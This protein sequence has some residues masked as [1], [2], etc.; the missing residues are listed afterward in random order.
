MGQLFQQIRR[1]K[2]VQ[3]RVDS[4]GHM[5]VFFPGA[6][7]RQQT[8]PVRQ[9]R[10]VG[11]YR[12]SI[13]QS[14]KR[15]GG[16]E[17][18]PCCV[19]QTSG[20]S[21]PPEGSMGLGSVFDQRN[22]GFVRDPGKSL[23]VPYLPI[24]VDGQNC[25]GL[26]GDGRP[27]TFRVQGEMVRLDIYEHRAGAHA[28]DRQARGNEGMG[29]DDHLISGA[30]VHCQQDQP[31]RVQAAGAACHLLYAQIGGKGLFKPAAAV[32]LDILPGLQDLPGGLQ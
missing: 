17:A 25:P 1:L 12:A 14:A 10:I 4:P 32:P 9:S 3:P 11:G 5:D 24:Q 22:A 20:L 15:F 2:L 7:V 30:H 21:A 28:A 8:H 31:Q 18:E 16:I 19:P 29:R 26:G 6:I 13:P 23:P 27:K